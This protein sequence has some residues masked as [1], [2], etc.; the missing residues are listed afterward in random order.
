MQNIP[1]HTKEIRLMF[2][3]GHTERDVVQNN[4]KFIF[5]ESEEVQKNSGEWCCCKNIVVGDSIV[6]SVGD[7]VVTSVYK[8]ED[9][10]ILSC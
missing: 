7:L 9:K 6:T 4:N 10:I 3:A 8:S 1:S 5:D 2:K